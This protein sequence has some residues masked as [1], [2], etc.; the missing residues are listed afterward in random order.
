MGGGGTGNLNHSQT[1]CSF[2]FPGHSPTDY[3]GHPAETL[4]AS[5]TDPTP[6]AIRRV[7]QL[8]PSE[9]PARGD[10][11]DRSHS[12]TVGAF[13]K[14]GK[15]GVRSFTRS[16]PH[17]TQLLTR[18]VHERAP[19]RAFGAVACFTNLEA[20]FHCDVNNDSCFDNWVCP[21]SRFQHGG[22]W[23]EQ[24]GGPV[25]K[26]ARGKN[27]AGVILDV[28]KGPVELPSHC[29]HCVLPWEG[30]RCVL[31]AFVPAALV[32]LPSADKGFMRDMGFHHPKAGVVPE[33][34]HQG[35]RLP[36]TAAS[37]PVPTAPVPPADLRASDPLGYP[38]A[39]P[40]PN[41]SGPRMIKPFALELFC[42]TAGVSAALQ[43]RGFE[44]LGVDHHL[45]PRRVKAPAVR[46][47]ISDPTQQ[48]VLL[49]EVRRADCIFLAP[50]CG[51]ASR[52]RS[53]PL[54]GR[55]PKP[56]PLRSLAFPEGLRK[57]TGVAAA[58]VT[59]AN[60]LYRFSSEVFTLCHRLGKVC[61]VENPTGSL[62]WRTRWFR[63]IEHLGC[64]NDHQACMYG[65]D[66]DKKTSLFSTHS[67]PSMQLMCNKQHAH[68]PWGRNK[69][70]KAWTFATSAEA[71]YPKGF[72]AALAKDVCDIMSSRGWDMHKTVPSH[73][74]LAAQAAQ[75]QARRDAPHH[76]P[77]GYLSRVT[78]QLPREL[79]VPSVIPEDAPEPLRGIP[80][81]SKML[82]CQ[83]VQK[84]GSIVKEA[85]FG[86]F[87][88]PD[89]FVKEALKM[90][91]PFELPTELDSSNVQAM[92]NILSSGVQG[93]CKF[94]ESVLSHY[95]QRAACLEQ[96]E[97]E[98]KSK[99]HPEVREIMKDKRLLL[100]A[101][102]LKDAGVNDQH[103]VDDLTNGFRI[104]GELKPSGLFP[105]IFRPAALSQ[106]D[107]R[108]TAKWSKHVVS[109]SCR[110]A[111]RDPDVAKAVWKETLEQ[112]DKKWLRG[113]FTFEEID[114]KYGGTWIASKR[115]GVVQG[116]KTRAVDDLSE[117]LINASVTET[118]KVILD[119][120]DNIIATA[121]FLVGAPCEDG[122]SFR[123]PCNDGSSF[124]GSL[125]EDFRGQGTS[126]QLYGRALDLKA[127]YKQL[128]RHPE[129]AWATV[130]AVL[131]PE[132]DRVYFFE[133]VALPFGGVSAVTGFN[134]AARS[135]KL[136]MSRLLWIINTSYYDDFCQIEVSGLEES[137]AQAA[138][139]FL[140]L[141]GWDIARGDK[142]KPFSPSFNIL[143][144]TVS[145]DRSMEGVINVSNKQ[146]R[147]PDLWELLRQM[148][149]DPGLRLDKL[150]SFKGRMLFATSHVFGRCAQICTQLI[151]QALKAA[152]PEEARDHV[153]KAA[154]LALEVL[155]EAGPREVLRW[156]EA[157]PVLVFTDGACEKDGAL[158]THGAVLLDPATGVQEFFGER[159]PDFLVQRWQGQGLKQLVFFAELLPVAVAKA[160]WQHILKNRLCIFFLDNEAARACLIRSFTPV[161]NATSI[162]MDVARQ[163]VA[164]H[165]L[166]WY[167][168][169]PS[170][171]NIA[172]DAS[173]L[174]FS[175]YANLFRMV[176]PV[177]DS[178]T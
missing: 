11:S 35:G 121:R 156:G 2:H 41:P 62:L 85:T 174:E 3:F 164:A 95:E 53:I 176:Q 96:A 144:V 13:S 92:A 155:S 130:L 74:A 59:S 108:A 131:C 25:C 78:V 12:F 137:A 150:A 134:R 136:A 127:A 63:A 138:E 159:V 79:S 68:L 129:D 173:R 50:P 161:A 1:A 73:T 143:G 90:I 76:G 113:P 126:P 9:V 102:V 49:Q 36:A 133:A 67:L 61:V 5:V 93:T 28:S 170:K 34:A 147:L 18:F 48:H 116:E 175:R 91:H 158:T 132:D 16:F 157:P 8:L 153:L 172:D 40:H 97:H 80:V 72:C 154:R 58:R 146:E 117:F 109:D 100:L 20:D 83:E 177:Y 57:L 70:G 171:S 123:L 69:S 44:V 135:L 77:S 17:V 105:R 38:T 104:T 103:L 22:I 163:D 65:S 26:F 19:G 167:A 52:A 37:V 7:L 51:T 86:I 56:K 140:A 165:S 54:K 160:T 75:R 24:A 142:L 148:E 27:R 47:D 87:R 166:N 178:I 88:T 31:V 168:R 149:S 29:L 60:K 33:A 66:R 21:L 128:A 6:E 71:E 106:D 139:R 39:L 107:L 94:R 101:E 125:H 115:F 111:S 55:G 23:V 43:R 14:N 42:G 46:V 45:R 169:V 10:A 15:V 118:D 112:K 81:G 122:V 32:N 84:G 152:R 82:Q 124:S 4:A 141:L 110:R 119:A 99:M 98:L 151:G 145:F 89:A 162:L 120:V 64:W 114:Q 30:T